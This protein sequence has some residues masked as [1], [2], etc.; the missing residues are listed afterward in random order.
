M[1]EDVP[2]QAALSWSTTAGFPPKAWKYIRYYKNITFPASKLIATAKELGINPNTML[3]PV[4]DPG[5][6]VYRNYVEAPLLGEAPVY[7]ELYHLAEDPDELHNLIADPEHSGTLETL[8]KAWKEEV[9]RARGEGVPLIL[10][11]T[12]D[13]GAVPG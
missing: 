11:Y 2:L 1:T 9:V 13:S 6:A 10:R 8:R 4:H 3:Y 5:I 12:A 7:E